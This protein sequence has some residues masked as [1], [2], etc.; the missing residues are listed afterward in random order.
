MSVAADIA[1]LRTRYPSIATVVYGD[2]C[3]VSRVTQADDGKGGWSDTW[4]LISTEIP[5]AFVPYPAAK[6]VVIAGKPKGMADGDAWL[7][8][9]HNDAALDVNEADR[10]I[11][12][13]NE[14][15]PERALEII[16]PAPHQGILIQ[17]VVRLINGPYVTGR[18][19]EFGFDSETPVSL[20]TIAADKVLR[21]ITVQ[22]R[23]AF[24]DP[25]ATLAVGVDGDPDSLMAESMIIPGQ[26]EAFRALIG[27]TFEEDTELLLTITPGSSTTGSGYVELEFDA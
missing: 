18:Q 17:A 16:F 3:S 26:V 10:L 23:E 5:M 24:D 7:P 15:E 25:A 1:S 4:S 12:A 8:A 2:R 21:S 6:E 9:L 14:S 13:A 20:G 27:T 22:V 19:V 11:V